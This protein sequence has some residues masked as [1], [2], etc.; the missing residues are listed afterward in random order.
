[1]LITRKILLF[2]GVSLALSVCLAFPSLSHE[3][4]HHK[5]DKGMTDH[6]KEM[7]A[8]KNEVPEEYRIM[9]RTPVTP[10]E[11]S[12]QQG[13]VLY[14]KSCAFCHGK[15][16][17][18]KGSAAAAMPTPPANFLD[19]KHSAIYGPGEKYWIIGNG[20]GKTGM[21]GFPKIA[22]LDRWHL[23]NYILHLQREGSTKEKESGHH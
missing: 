23:V 3:K 9:D 16:G 6:M 18:G 22:P 11:E 4:K 17:D 12:L 8:L 19:K 7:Y 10:A 21:P 15:T 13:Q 2:T 14:K 20:S 1:M 5:A